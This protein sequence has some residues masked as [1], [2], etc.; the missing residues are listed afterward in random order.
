MEDKRGWVPTGCA[1][2]VGLGAAVGTVP[3]WA[4]VIALTV[5]CGPQ[6]RATAE[7]VSSIVWQWKHPDCGCHT[8]GEHRPG[9]TDRPGTEGRTSGA[10]EARDR[11]E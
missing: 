9:L 6:V 1:S 5:G 11:E 10:G 3:W 8:Q 7:T 4:V 2:V